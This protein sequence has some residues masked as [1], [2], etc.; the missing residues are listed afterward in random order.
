MQK[1]GNISSYCSIFIFSIVTDVNLCTETV[2][3]QTELAVKYI[4]FF[5]SDYWS[6]MLGRNKWISRVPSP[7]DLKWSVEDRGLHWQVTGRRHVKNSGCWQRQIR[8]RQHWWGQ[9]VASK[10]CLLS[11]SLVAIE[12]KTRKLHR[13]N[14][15]CLFFLWVYMCTRVPAFSQ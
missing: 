2:T 13:N 1:I 8:P 5:Q 3:I 12:A 9:K 15:C 4:N 14:S 7:C 11:K 6:F 10:T